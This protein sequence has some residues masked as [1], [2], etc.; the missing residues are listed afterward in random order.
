MKAARIY[1]G[2]DEKRYK[3]DLKN[4]MG[5]NP[6]LIAWCAY[7]VKAIIEKHWG[8]LEKATGL[9]RSF[10]KI[11]KE[12]G[13]DKAKEGDIVVLKRGKLPWQGHVGF[14]VKH[15]KNFVTLLGGNQGNKVCE[16]R[17]PVK[18]ILGIRRIK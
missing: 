6:A 16:K 11:G 18:A 5:V 13:L 4:L 3:E 12:V 14:Y 10:L 17:Y 9:A 2:M 15:S 1:E 8:L 7:F